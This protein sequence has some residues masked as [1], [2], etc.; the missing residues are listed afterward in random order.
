MVEQL[1]LA[2]EDRQ[3][4]VALHA[5]L[6]R[7]VP[8]FRA[9]LVP[10]DGPDGR[11]RVQGD[12]FK[13][14]GAQPFCVF[15]EQ[16]GLQPA[17]TVLTQFLQ[18]ARDRVRVDAPVQPEQRT[19]QPVAA[20]GGDPVHPVYPAQGGQYDG[21]QYL[22]RA[23]LGGIVPLRGE[24]GADGLYQPF[25]VHVPGQPVETGILGNVAPRERGFYDKRLAV[26]F[27]LRIFH[28]ENDVYNARF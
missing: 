2:Y 18:R 13:A 4:V 28:L 8:F 15:R 10:V 22:V 23:E 24:K 17:G 20:E 25:P 6:P 3:R 1:H 27:F 11:V 16:H 7:V 26:Q 19:Y 9:L 14:A 12:L 5:I 21:R